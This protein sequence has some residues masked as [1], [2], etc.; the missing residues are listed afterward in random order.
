VP[1]IDP[2]GE[3]GVGSGAD[4]R[5]FLIVGYDLAE[6]CLGSEK[7]VVRKLQFGKIANDCDPDGS[8]GNIEVVGGGGIDFLAMRLRVSDSV[9]RAD[10]AVWRLVW[11][12]DECDDCSGDGWAL[13]TKAH[14]IEDDAGAYGTNGIFAL[15]IGNEG[16]KDGVGGL[17]DEAPKHARCCAANVCVVVGEVGGYAW[18]LGLEERQGI[19]AE[20]VVGIGAAFN[21]N[22]TVE[23]QRPD[24]GILVIDGLHDVR[25]DLFYIGEGCFAESLGQ[26]EDRVKGSRRIAGI[27]SVNTVL[28]QGGQR[29]RSLRTGWHKEARNE[30]K[31]QSR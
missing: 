4:G 8:L 17:D 16:C 13:R 15:E 26:I 9:D 2:T 6:V 20:G 3:D 28:E 22:D 30:Y 19:A 31:E 27:G 18:D 25:E 14:E 21:S 5:V 7:D 23:G 12:A 29:R 11:T 1:I 24:G 10:E